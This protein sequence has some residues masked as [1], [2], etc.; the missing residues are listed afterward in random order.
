MNA[1][2][3]PTA[4]IQAR[5]FLSKSPMR[6]SD[7]V[8]WSGL[9]RLDRSVKSSTTSTELSLHLTLITRCPAGDWHML[10]PPGWGGSIVRSS[11]MLTVQYIPLSWTREEEDQF[12]A[13]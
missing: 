2:F 4:P 7:L 3:A 5:T 13:C 10:K 11:M 1:L 8:N 9:R 12:E 6:L